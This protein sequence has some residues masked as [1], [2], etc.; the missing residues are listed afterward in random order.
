MFGS[1][2][3]GQSSP[4]SRWTVMACVVQRLMIWLRRYLPA[5]MVCTPAALLGAWLAATFTSNGAAIALAATWCEII[6]FYAV[7]LVRDLR[8]V[9]A[10][11]LTARIV[12]VT[13]RNTCVE[14]GPAEILD[15]LLVRPIALQLSMAV[16]PHLALSIMIGKLFADV[17]FYVPTIAA[18]ELRMRHAK[19][20]GLNS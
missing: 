2:I 1:N 4:G 11:H 6:V 14:F 10:S 15:S 5:E 18:Y 19:S 3:R 7:M 20:R 16:I 9:S 12:L 8:S 13:V 17:L